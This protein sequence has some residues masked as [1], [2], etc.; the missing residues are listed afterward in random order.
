MKR[1]IL[2]VSVAFLLVAL[3]LGAVVLASSNGGVEPGQASQVTAQVDNTNANSN[4]GYLFA[5]Y[6]ITWAGFFGYIFIVSRRQRSLEHEIDRLEGLL[7]QRSESTE[8]G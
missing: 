8:K 7:E 1:R 3:P 5:V 4:L 6:I 2:A